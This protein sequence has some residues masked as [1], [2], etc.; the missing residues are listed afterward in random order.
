[1]EINLYEKNSES[2]RKITACKTDSLTIEMLEIQTTTAIFFVT[3]NLCNLLV[4]WSVTFVVQG[5]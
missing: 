5:K 3:V 1:M 4:I 2:V